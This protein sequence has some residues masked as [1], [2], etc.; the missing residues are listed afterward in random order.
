LGLKLQKYFRRD[1]KKLTQKIF[2]KKK[3]AKGTHRREKSKQKCGAIKNNTLR[4]LIPFYLQSI[5]SGER[6]DSQIIK[7]QIS[8][9]KLFN[10][11]QNVGQSRS[12]TRL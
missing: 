2:Q 9:F 8:Q 10:K 5:K 1:Q 12:L 11:S 4:W 3:I 6:V 7:S